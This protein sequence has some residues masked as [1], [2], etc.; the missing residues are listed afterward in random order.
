MGYAYLA[1]SA[2]AETD[3]VVVTVADTAESVAI[4]VVSVDIVVTVESV[5][6]SSVLGLLWQAA[7]VRVLPMNRSAKTFFIVMAGKRL[8]RKYK[9]F[10]ES[11]K[12][13][14]SSTTNA[15]WNVK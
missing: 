9:L 5:V 11:T 6:V 8:S 14:R 7:N 10:R 3:S 1:L 15:H 13:T 4:V 2:T 12:K